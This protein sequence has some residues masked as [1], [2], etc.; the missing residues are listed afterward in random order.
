MT[1]APAISFRDVWKVFGARSGE[2]AAAARR[3]GLGKSAVRDDYG[4]VLAVAGVSLDI[5]PGELFCVMGLS[6]SGKSTLLR[7]VN[8]LIAPTGGEVTVDG[9][10]I[11]R[12]APAALRSL[13]A[14]KIGMVFQSFALLP[15]RN[16]LDNVAFGLE[17]QGVER[18]ERERRA[19]DMLERV[20]LAG[21][22]G[23]SVAA[24][25]GGMQQRVGLARALC[26]DPEILLMDEPFGALD[27]LIRHQLQSQFL[28]LSR[29]MRKT[30]VFIT[31]D[32]DE[33]MRI[34]SRIAIMKDGALLQVGLPHEIIL[35]PANAHV[36]EF[37]SGVSTKDALQA[38]HVMVPVAAADAGQ[39]GR[40][41]TVSAE[42]SLAELARVAARSGADVAIVAGSGAIIG[43]ASSGR[44]LGGGE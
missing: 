32:L 11:A 26:G 43:R 35:D 20:Q 38:R 33:A 41:E 1:D 16:V 29:Q 37:V 17:L 12:L 10:T 28:A 19:R 8:G 27:P 13:R 18:Q 22:E 40:A 31:H 24:L 15:H 3:D 36:A 39:L 44:M 25:S 14:R 5:M 4:C 6:G 34:G 21:W 2:A 30:T 9:E 23:A 7:L 42:A